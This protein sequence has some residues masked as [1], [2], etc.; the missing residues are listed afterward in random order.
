MGDREGSFD[1]VCLLEIVSY[2]ALWKRLSLF[3]LGWY[4][5]QWILLCDFV[6]NLSVSPLENKEFIG[7]LGW[8]VL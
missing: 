5:V 1:Y 4:E 6:E 8:S 3:V 2:V 7:Y